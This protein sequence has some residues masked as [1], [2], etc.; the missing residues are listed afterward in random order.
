MTKAL[1]DL[2]LNKLSNLEAG[3]V[4]KRNLADI[5]TIPVGEITDTVMKN[6]IISLNTKEVEY[7][8]ALVQVQKNDETVKIEVADVK[9][10]LSIAA[11]GAS[12]HLGSLSDVSAERDAA[13][14]LNTL[15]YTYANLSKLN[16]EAESNGL[17]NFGKD[18]VNAKYAPFV[19][20]LGIGKYVVRMQTDNDFFK[21]LYGGRT[22]G[23]AHTEVYNAKQLRKDLL[24]NYG[25]FTTYLLSM[26]ENLDTAQFNDVLALVNAGRKQYADLL[27]IREGKAA[28]EKAKAAVV[29]TVVN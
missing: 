24:I 12:V 13:T 2:N 7:D 22:E 9:R 3:Q 15:F 1:T 5:A 28:S 4:V 6:F 21:T 26:A 20:L 29:T 27:A 8:K 25:K 23:I 19:A 16:Y 18:L 11:F 17:D 10:D 14:S